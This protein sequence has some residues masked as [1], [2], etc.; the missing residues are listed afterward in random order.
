MRAPSAAPRRFAVTFAHR[1]RDCESDI[2]TDISTDIRTVLDA[3][4]RC[5]HSAAVTDALRNAVRDAFAVA[6]IDANGCPDAIARAIADRHVA[7]IFRTDRST[8]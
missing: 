7:T 6:L 8:G 3:Y 1:I 4:C 2:S 5:E